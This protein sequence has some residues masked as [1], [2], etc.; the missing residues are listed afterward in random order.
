VTERIVIL[1]GGFA[2]LWS[3]L[4]AARARDASG[5][6]ADRLEIV[7]INDT[8]WHSIRVRNYEA[9]LEGTRVSLDSVLGPVGIH[10]IE[11][12][13]S[14]IDVARRTV[15]YQ[16]DGAARTLTYDRL[17][18]ALGSRL[19]RP[20]IP[21]LREHAFD[22][23]THAAAERLNAHIAG[24][25]HREPSPGQ[26]TV[27]VVGGGL[28]G[29]EAATEMP[30]KLRAAGVASPRVILADHARRV[31]SGMGE[32]ALPVIDEALG[33]LGIE[34]RGGVSVAA[35]D[36]DGATLDS[37]E[38]IAAA[39]IVW[40]AGMQAHP[41]TAQFPVERDRLGRL[42]VEPSLKIRG[43]AAE[44]AAGDAA[45]F[46]VDDVHCS[47]MSCQHGR[48]M[49]RFA[50]H[51]VVCDLLG[52]PLLPL[53]IEW[54]TTILDLG[55]WGAV[56][57][58]GWDRKLVSRGADAKRTKEL[59]NRERIYPPRSGERQAILDAAAPTVQAPPIRF[60]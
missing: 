36:A 24:L 17:V 22:V 34:A 52:R 59:I 16:G 44:F 43:L 51:N 1:G 2:G 10:R 45:W 42:P 37:G 56:Y 35:I 58:E 7:L 15:A 53:R 20:P 47:V 28:T 14:T 32:G 25:A 9:D 4:G 26:F 18:F 13:V 27:L 48:P 23:D 21:G 31:G 46:L 6:G 60:G 49:G 41:L 11:G 57:T 55:P 54:Y 5:I 29:I 30:G 39:T 12:E 19:A 8:A 50:G 40:C 33:A 38:R 3:A